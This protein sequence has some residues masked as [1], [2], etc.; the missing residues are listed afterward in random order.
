MDIEEAIEKAMEFLERKGGQ[1]THRLVNVKLEGSVWKIKFDTG[2]FAEN[3][4]ELEVDDK[5]GR[6]V[7]YEASE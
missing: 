3:L 6:I 1:Y 5:T 4:T 2:I 7:K